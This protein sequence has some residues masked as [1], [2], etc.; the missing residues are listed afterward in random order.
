MVVKTTTNAI[1]IGH[2][3]AKP[4]VWIEAEGDPV[5]IETIF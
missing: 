3:V 2:L 5:V 4:L 1:V